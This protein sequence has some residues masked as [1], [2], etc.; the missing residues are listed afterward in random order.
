[1][2]PVCENIGIMAHMVDNLVQPNIG[3]I[4]DNSGPDWLSSEQS[5]GVS[6]DKFWHSHILRLE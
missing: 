6:F 1:M 2:E 3:S 4:S 5:T